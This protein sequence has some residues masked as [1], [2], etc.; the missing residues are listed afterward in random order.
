MAPAS[1]NLSLRSPPRRAAA[2]DGLLANLQEM[3]GVEEAEELDAHGH[4]S[5]PAGLVAGPQAGAVVTMKVLVE[6]KVVAP[7]GVGLERLGPSVDGPATAFIAQKDAREA[8]CDLPGYLE[9]G[10][11]LPRPGGAFHPKRVA[12]IEIELQQRSDDEGVHRPPDRPAPIG[13]AAE[14]PAVRLCRQIRDAVFLAPHVKHVGMSFVKFGERADA[15]GA[16]KLLLVKHGREHP[17]QPLWGQQGPEPPLAHAIMARAS[18]MDDTQQ[19]RYLPQA[20]L[21]EGQRTRDT[22]PLPGLDHRRGT[23]RQESHHRAHLE[24]R[25]AAVR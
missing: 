5:R 14:H 1:A 8:R 12:V 18:G 25:G 19:L 9:E 20:L 15:V 22:L 11:H 3:L 23:E 24:Q 13:V 16:E 10:Q 4:E 17:A 7:M 2:K 6:E 21:E